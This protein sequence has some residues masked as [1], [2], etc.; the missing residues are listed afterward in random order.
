MSLKKICRM[1]K[2]NNDGVTNLDGALSSISANASAAVTMCN[3]PIIPYFLAVKESIGAMHLYLERSFYGEPLISSIRSS[4]KMRV[5]NEGQSI[6][7]T[8]IISPYLS[9]LL[10][11]RKR[12]KLMQI[13]ILFPSALGGY[14]SVQISDLILRG[15]PDPVTAAIWELK[16]VISSN[17]DPVTKDS[18][19]RMLN[20]RLSPFVNTELLCQDP[21]CL[22]LL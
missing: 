5:P 6:K 15:F 10:S 4:I 8:E 14:P 7:I 3:F 16:L 21:T 17:M 9:D 20:P 1:H 12:Y 13:L 2:L 18:V 22:N 19:S 11:S